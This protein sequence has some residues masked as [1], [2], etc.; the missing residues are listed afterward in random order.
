[1]SDTTC[2][3]CKELANLGLPI[4]C[5][6]CEAKAA[7]PPVAIEPPSNLVSIQGGKLKDA[8]VNV[9][10]IKPA[11]PRGW[12]CPRCMW[13][14]APSMHVCVNCVGLLLKP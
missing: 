6:A 11:T 3:D 8:E 1:M 12:E 2:I 9:S 5:K 10:K 14:M 4:K 13:V 7:V